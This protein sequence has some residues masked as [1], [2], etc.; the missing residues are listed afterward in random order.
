MKYFKKMESKN[1]YLAPM[2][3]S[4]AEKYCHWMNDKEVMKPYM[5][6]N[7]FFNKLM[8]LIDESNTK[9]ERDKMILDLFLPKIFSDDF[10]DISKIL[11]W[12]LNYEVSIVNVNYVPFNFKQN[13]NSTDFHKLWHEVGTNYILSDEQIMDFSTFK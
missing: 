8:L 11:L 5:T 12:F 3:V 7:E 13:Q 10:N 2:M 9:E 1:L 4:D 6:I